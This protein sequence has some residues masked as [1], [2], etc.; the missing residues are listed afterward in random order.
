M[1]VGYFYWRSDKVGGELVSQEERAIAPQTGGCSRSAPP[2]GPLRVEALLQAPS[3]GLKAPVVQGTGDA[4]LD[5]AVGHEANSAWPQNPGTTVLAAHDVT[6]FSELNHLHSG[7]VITYAEPCRTY[8]YQV[9][10]AQVVRTGAPIPATST[11]T[12][13]LITCWPLDALFV[14]PQRYLLS[15]R[16]VSTTRTAVAPAAPT[17]PPAGPQVSIPVPLLAQNLS[18]ANN[19]VPLG[20]LG[21]SGSPAPAWQQSSRPLQVESSVLEL[22]FGALRSAEQRQSAWWSQLAPGVPFS[23]AGPL[24]SASISKEAGN[25][26]P[27]IGVEGQQ[28]RTATVTAQPVL[29]GGAAPG[30]YQVTMSASVHGETLVITNWQMQRTG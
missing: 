24:Y 26:Q 29:S 13:A 18:L 19:N 30:R 25:V 1:N 14:S 27:S 12:L 10:G 5:V 4:Q 20:T 22:F 6:W 15:A 3:I 17:S 8:H 7:D 21:L 2:S 11:P 16:L 28:V 23:A 9:T